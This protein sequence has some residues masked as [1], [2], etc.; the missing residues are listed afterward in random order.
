MC[1]QARVDGEADPERPDHVEV[2]AGRERRQPAGAAADALVEELEPAAF[3]IDPIDAL[4]PPQP[5]VAV[6]GGRAKQVE[7]LAWLDGQ[8][9]GRG[10][11]HQMLVFGIDP[12]M[13]DDRTEQLLGRNVRRGRRRR[14]AAHLER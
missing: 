10:V 8:R 3:A 14:A 6:V 9:L 1:F 2:V 7:E 4:R 5:Q 13:R 11:D 12:A